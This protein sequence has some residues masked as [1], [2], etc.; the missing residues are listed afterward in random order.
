M[1]HAR[2]R[3]QMEREERLRTRRE[4]YRA[5]RNRETPEQ[6]EERLARRREYDRGRYAQMTVN[7]RRALSQRRRERVVSEKRRQ[8]EQVAATDCND[9][10]VTRQLPS[11]DN[12][13]IKSPFSMIF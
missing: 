5:R 7:Q 10:A 9:S 1:N 6:R 3:L 2:I 8:G 12:P 4:Q 11:F 13:F